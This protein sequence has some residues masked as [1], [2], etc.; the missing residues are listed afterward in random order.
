VSSRNQHERGLNQFTKD[1]LYGTLVS[2]TSKALIGAAALAGAAVIAL[3]AAGWDVP[4]WTLAATTFLAVVLAYVVRRVTARE[5]REMAPRLSRA[6]DELDRHDS[7]GSNLC[8]ALETFQKIVAKDVDLPMGTFIERGILAPARD[9]M[10]ENGH[11]A[12]LRMSVLLV[13]NGH[14]SM[15]W[16]SGHNI[17]SQKKFKVPVENTISKV[18]FEKQAIQVWRNAPAEERGFIINPKATRGFKSM[19]S[20]PISAGDDTHG[21]F[22][23]VTEDEDAFDPA[24]V[25]YLTS[26]GAVIQLAFGLALAEIE[27]RRVASVQAPTRRL[28]RPRVAP[29]KAVSRGPD[30]GQTPGGV[31]GS[32]DT[33]EGTEASDE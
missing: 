3:I 30:I 17:E 29:A 14:F 9:V 19:V 27:T 25:N 13:S 10:R 5:A 26:V 15:A 28:V 20:I 4:A 23:I 24:D 32:S 11:A 8:S 22:N 6:E 12:D 31:V 33:A 1:V 2:V 16:A 18:A 21:V 7:Y